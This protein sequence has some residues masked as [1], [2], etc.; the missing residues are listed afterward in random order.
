MTI[1]SVLEKKGYKVFKILGNKK[2]MDAVEGM[3]AFKVGAALVVDP[4]DKVQGIFTERDVTRILA[5]NGPSILDTTVATHMTPDPVTCKKS[6]SVQDVLDVMSAKR[7]RHM[8][9]FEDGRL[10]GMI[11]IRDLVSEKLQVV[12]FEA[13]ELRAYVTAS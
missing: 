12:E 8:P 7:F 9:V 6:D 4:D 11:S 2:V 10:I 3:A 5:A 13:E 1:A